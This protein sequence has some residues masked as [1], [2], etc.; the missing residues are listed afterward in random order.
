MQCLK[1]ILATVM[2]LFSNQAFASDIATN[3]EIKYSNDS[4]KLDDFYLSN[5]ELRWLNSK[6]QFVI[7]IDS[8]MHSALIKKEPNQLAKGIGADYLGLLQQ[9]LKVRLVLRVY[10]HAQD[11]ASAL[12]KGEVDMILTDLLNNS[13]QKKAFN[14][15]KPLITTFPSLITTV[16]GTMS[17]LSTNKQVRIARVKGYPGNAEILHDFPNAIIID[18]AD[19]YEALSSVSSGIDQYFLGSN[20]ITSK[21]ISEYFPHSL[22]IIKYYKNPRQYSFFYTRKEMPLLNTILNRFVSNLT[23]DVRRDIISNWL[24]TG[25]LGFLEQPLNFTQQEKKWLKKH[26]SVKILIPSFHPPFSMADQQGGPRGIMGDLLNI[27]ELQTG[28]KFESIPSKSLPS[29][30]NIQQ[31]GGWDVLAGAVYYEKR[32]YQAAFSDMIMSLPYVY[33]MKKERNKNRKITPGMK[34]G[35]PSYY[36]VTDELKKLNPGVIWV[37]IDYP[38]TAFQQVQVGELDALVVTQPTAK[39]MIEHYYPDS[40]LFFRVPDVPHAEIAFAFPRGETELKSIM[41]K[42][43]NN[44]PDSEML[45]LI[46]KWT[47][48]PK[49]KIDTWNLYSKQFYIFAAIAISLTISSVLWGVYLLREVNRRRVIQ[50][51]LE[52]QLSLRK[53]L[54][55]SL[56]TPCYVVD[57]DGN[58]LSHNRAFARYFT[59]AYYANALQPLSSSSS[60]FSY[61]MSQLVTMQFNDNEN[62]PVNICE[63]KISNGLENRNIKH[64]QTFCDMPAS[65]DRVFICGWEDVTDTSTLIQELEIEKNKAINATIAKSQFLATMSHEIRTPVSSIMGFL[66][67]LTQN[68]QSEE[69][70]IEAINLAYSTGQSLINL[71]GEILDIDK[72]ESGRYQLQEQ[73][74]NISEH[75]TN[76]FNAFDLLAKRKDIS[77]KF[78]NGLDKN[79]LL[80]ID[81]QAIKQVLT[82]LL[83]NALK[84]TDT[85]SVILTAQLHTLNKNNG[86]L[87]IEVL[88]SGIGISAEAQELLFKPYSQIPCGREHQGSGLG[89]MICKHLV[90]KMKGE[91]SV[92]SK[93][94]LGSTFL[95]TIPVSLNISECNNYYIS[96]SS[97]SLP[98]NLHVLIA[99]DHP[100]NRLLLK[101]QLNS[102]G[103]EVTE[104]CDGEDALNKACNKYYDLLITDVSMPHLDGFELT[105][106]LRLKN[107]NLPIWGLTANAQMHERERGLDSGMNLCLFKPLTL[108][109]L[110]NYLS[111]LPSFL[112]NVKVNRQLNIQ[113]LRDNTDS[114]P[115]M[116]R[117]L[118][119]TFISSARDDLKMALHAS[120][121]N[122]WISFKKHIHRIHGSSQILNLV[123]LSEICDKLESISEIA[124]GHIFKILMSELNDLI[125][126]LEDEINQ[127]LASFSN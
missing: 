125:T 85:G 44:L 8:T 101:R 110:K 83:S 98:S 112:L 29:A 52:N 46:D 11:A 36:G 51:N 102:L 100:T 55:D 73:L 71:I 93:P 39:Y 47:K 42:A 66:E 113:M 116:I 105:K 115:E 65:A 76:I 61:I 19:H 62:R 6:K 87:I 94:G 58:I 54:S 17:P 14:I 15:S 114:D 30:E 31:N 127:Y 111:Q 5:A 56:P 32:H 23:N 25:N 24:S 126:N 67:I 63:M 80:M 35:I 49:I 48:I 53:A 95:I 117:E 72:I 97:Y 60:P 106:A 69:Q 13:Q 20:L 10:H 82:N 92:K 68:S 108:D 1:V 109:M 77:L 119:Q 28:I 104:A 103:Y 33:V 37:K 84:F 9:H 122:D 50:G 41:N 21:L 124:E 81:P 70:K 89:L 91:I 40:Q 96:K 57:F 2:I 22:N 27:I 121:Q 74:I 120:E 16:N 86:E 43:L 64:W 90:E 18:Y 88:D 123:N 38:C 7:A 59:S 34:I 26:Q 3:Y 78:K 45:H 4:I 99:D 118:L 107:K 12:A 75:L 79:Q